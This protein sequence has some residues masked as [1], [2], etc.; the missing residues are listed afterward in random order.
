LSNKNIE[1]ERIR[2]IIYANLDRLFEELEKLNQNLN[3]TGRISKKKKEKV[4]TFGLG[5]DQTCVL[6]K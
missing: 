2:Q 6:K 4:R 1:Q 5:K 3:P